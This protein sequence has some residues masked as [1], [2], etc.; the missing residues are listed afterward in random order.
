M[1]GYEYPW[2]QFE[3]FQDFVRQLVQSLYEMKVKKS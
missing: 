2:F 1:Q 3:Q